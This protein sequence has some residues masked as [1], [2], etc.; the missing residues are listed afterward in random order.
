MGTAVSWLDGLVLDRGISPLH[1]AVSELFRRC[2]VNGALPPRAALP[3]EPVL[4]RQLGIARATLRQALDTLARDGLIRREHGRGNFVI[5]PPQSNGVQDSIGFT[6]EQSADP[7]ERLTLVSAGFASPAPAVA[8]HLGLDSGASVFR[9]V[10]VRS[11]D[12]APIA[13]EHI[14]LPRSA[15]TALGGADLVSQRILRIVARF[16]GMMPTHAM[17]RLSIEPFEP[18]VAD[19]LDLAS[20]TIGLARLCVFKLQERAIAVCVTFHPPLQTAYVIAGP[21]SN[22]TI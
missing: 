22:F 11:L 21:A 7:Q 14:H 18:S 10:R 13:V 6:Y 9:I 15:A 3:S 16:A 1:R 2:I 5:G 20:N 12:A 8:D 19:Q 17:Q 4:A